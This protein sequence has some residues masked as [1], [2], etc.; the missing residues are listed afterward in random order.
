MATLH[1][2]A[3]LADVKLQALP[4]DPVTGEEA[5]KVISAIH[6]VPSDLAKRVRN[7]LE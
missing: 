3:F 5:E 1:N 6:A 2:E 4:L 7:V